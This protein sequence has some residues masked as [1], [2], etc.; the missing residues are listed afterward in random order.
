MPRNRDALRKS[1]SAAPGWQ[2]VT[3]EHTPG[4]RG[5]SN[6]AR[7]DA[8]PGSCVRDH[9]SG[10]L[11][12]AQRRTL[13]SRVTRESA[14]DA[15][16]HWL[17]ADRNRAGLAYEQLR[18]R[19]VRYFEWRGCEASDVLADEVLDRVARR[20]AEGIDVR[21]E[22]PRQYVY[23]VA[24]LVRLEAQKRQGKQRAALN[25]LPKAGWRAG[26][27]DAEELDLRLQR[28]LDQ[29]DPEQRAFIL[30]YYD[31]EGQDRIKSRRHMADEMGLALNAL[32]IRAHRLRERLAACLRATVGTDETLWPY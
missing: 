30:R 3:T 20:L 10:A 32:R 16:L 4:M 29:L 9:G 11:V 25:A 21:A 19:L 24:R 22:D 14:F 26:D 7:R 23:G 18:E 31:S 27:R 17:D 2:G 6:A 13:S 28:C 15:L 12:A 1:R 8:P 5:R